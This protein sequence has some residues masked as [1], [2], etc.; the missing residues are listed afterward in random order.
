MVALNNIIWPLAAY[1][2]GSIPF[3]LL[4]AKSRGVDLRQH[5]S[6]NIG[7]TNVARTLGKSFGLMTL[8]A[9]ISKGLLPVLGCKFLGKDLMN[10]QFILSLTGL[11]AVAGHCFPV[12][13]G[14]R[15]GKGVATAVGVFL[16]L[17]PKALAFAAAGFIA[18]V[19]V[20]GYVS[21]G[22]LSAS[23]IMPALIHMFCPGHF[24]EP[25]AWSI[26]IIIWFRHQDNIRRLFSGQEKSWKKSGK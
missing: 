22:S 11:A 19:K 8:M 14:F 17:C 3:G 16:G 7:A 26:A 2:L 24:V 1:L 20:S 23:A 10:V 21:L 6:G 18:V 4:M 13:L 5:G 25:M 9:D 15:G 12:F